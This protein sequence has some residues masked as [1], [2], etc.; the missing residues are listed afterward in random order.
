METSRAAVLTVRAAVRGAVDFTRARVLDTD[1]W[2]RTNVI[3][4]AAGREDDLKAMQAA[5]AYQCA[6]V[7]NGSLTEESFKDSQSAARELFQEVLNR[8][9]PWAAATTTDVRQ[10]QLQGLIANYRKYVGD[11]DSPAFKAKLLQE[12]EEQDARARGEVVDEKPPED[13]ED[14]IDRLLRER[15]ARR[16]GPGK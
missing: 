8:L 10:S 12:L 7:S 3:I 11:P 4:R 15:D 5:F 16:T 13:D 6:L 14:R 1:W 2:R 9:Q